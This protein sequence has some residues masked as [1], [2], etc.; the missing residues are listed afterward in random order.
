LPGFTPG[1]SYPF[2]SAYKGLDTDALIWSA[3]VNKMAGD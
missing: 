3:T 1:I 2:A